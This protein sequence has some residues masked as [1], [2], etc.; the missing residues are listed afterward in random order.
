MKYGKT[1]SELDVEKSII[2]RD[3]VKKIIEYGVNENQKIKI[4]KLL[5]MELENRELMIEIDNILKSLNEKKEHSKKLI[6][7]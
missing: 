6:S 3:I 1:N 7:I 4:I 2:C 5:S